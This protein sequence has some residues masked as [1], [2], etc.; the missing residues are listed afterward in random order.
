MLVIFW[1]DPI[2]D[3]L[4]LQHIFLAQY[5]LGV[6]VLP[7]R[8]KDLAS[9]SLAIF[10]GVTA[11]RRLHLQQH[12]FF[13]GRRIFGLHTHRRRKNQNCSHSSSHR[14]PPTNRFFILPNGNILSLSTRPTTPGT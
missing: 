10:L 2:S 3:P 14:R 13:V 6:L 12:A 7:V 9:D 4:R 1:P 5:F 8:S 11:R